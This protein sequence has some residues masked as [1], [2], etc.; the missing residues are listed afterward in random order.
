MKPSYKRNADPHMGQHTTTNI[1]DAINQSFKKIAPFWPLKNLIAVNPLQGLEDHPIEDA[2]KLAAVYFEQKDLPKGME[3]VNRETIKWLQA[4][5]DEGQATITM[6]LRA[7]GL[8]TAWRSLAPYDANLHKGNQLA[9]KQLRLLPQTARE[10]IIEYLLRLGIAKEQYAQFL[11]L[12]LTTL[13]GWAAY[14][15][16]RT[17]WAG[18][19]SNHLYQTAQEDYLALRLVTTSLLWPEAKKLLSWHKT[20]FNQAPSKSGLLEKIVIT[21][22]KYRDTLLKNLAKQPLKAPNIPEAQLVFCIDVR[23]E[24]LRTCLESTGNYQT[25][26]FAGFFGLPVQ[27]NNP[28]T[29]ESYASCPVLL[30]PKHEVEETPCASQACQHD[31]TGYERLST[32]KLLYQSVKYTFTAPFA[33]VESIGIFT[34]AWMALRSLLPKTASQI[35]AVTVETLRKP[36]EIKPALDNI[37]LLDQC[38]YALNALQMIGLTSHFA[39]VVVFCGHGSA[40]QNNAYATALDCGACGGRHGG[41]N[42]RIL[43]AILNRPVVRTQ[44]LNEGIIIPQATLFIAAEHNTTTDEV[45]LYGTDDRPKIKKLKE[46]LLKAREANCRIRLQKMEKNSIAAHASSSL[47]LR[48]QDWAQVRPEWGLAQNSAFIVAPRD[49]TSTLDLAG[50]C[51]LH[52]YDYKQDPEGSLLTVILTAPMVVAQWINVQYFFSTLDNAAYGSGSKITQNITG[53][54]G[55]M[56]GNASDLMTGLPLQSVYSNDTEAYHELQRLLTVVFAP[57]HTLDNIL[58]SQPTLQKLLGNGWVQL[59]AL[60]PDNRKIYLLNRD[61]SWQEMHS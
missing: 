2:L 61:F 8:Y 4:Y 51:F 10:A 41:S 33:L 25:F 20:A 43:A 31:K 56:Q 18:K 50:R 14:I 60:Q 12:M 48:S 39:P 24:P 40:T 11:T 54:M 45:V 7:H 28:I 9:Q 17:E 57:R 53:K 27:I 29:Q 59:A 21:E 38:T 47:W 13:P 6:P 22:N 35:K 5:F 3:A 15:K 52:S 23:S 37:S 26:G 49:I 32:L 36:Q 19:H 30:T 16:Y 58:R 42:A 55:I 44:L 46:N 34:G 1:A